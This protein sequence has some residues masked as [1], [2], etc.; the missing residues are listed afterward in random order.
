VKVTVFARTSAKV[1]IFS[2]NIK[3]VIIFPT[4]NQLLSVQG[5]ELS[6]VTSNAIIIG[7]KSN[8]PIIAA[9]SFEVVIFH[10]K[11]LC[12]QP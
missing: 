5:K 9:F 3:T 8:Y 6:L 4:L 2:Q 11:E 12:F 10:K 1:A 7:E